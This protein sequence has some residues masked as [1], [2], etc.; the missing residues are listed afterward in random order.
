MHHLRS[1]NGTAW[2]W[3]VMAFMAMNSLALM[4]MRAE[5]LMAGTAVQGLPCTI[6]Y[7][8][9]IRP[10]DQI[11][12]VSTRQLGCQGCGADMSRL[13]C[14]IYDSPEG[15]CSRQWRSVP[16]DAFYA[17][18][19]ADIPTIVY[20]HGNRISPGED[21]ERGF[22]VYRALMQHS[23]SDAPIRFLI[24]S[25]P[26]TE[27]RR[28]L[29]DFRIKADLSDQTAH[30]LAWVI[31]RI[32]PDVRIA[33]V[34]YSYGARVISGA[35]HLL[36]G[37]MQCGC[38]LS[39][40]IHPVRTPLRVVYL[41]P[42]VSDSWMLPGFCHEMAL[43]QVDHML[44]TINP[45]DPAMKYFHMSTYRSERS[46]RCRPMALGA[47]GVANLA[48]LGE[49]ASR[50]EQMNVCCAVGRDHLEVSYLAAWNFMTQAW[51]VASFQDL[52]D[53]AC[54]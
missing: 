45:C 8:N 2:F 10:Q 25:W 16:L 18:D 42:A 32:S 21:Q 52:A 4:D 31:D 20:V 11:F 47:Y 40:R 3:A 28:P 34:G 1:R 24:F 12:L 36:G 54:H 6:Q 15:G 5:G 22:M 43:S 13:A 49:S 33:L 27:G 7:E 29:K 9:G 23:Q 46:R 38:G 26:T 53:Q 17:A 19:H 48:W 14:Q 37:G 30:P 35:L 41:A 39:E 51:E 44:L 50:I